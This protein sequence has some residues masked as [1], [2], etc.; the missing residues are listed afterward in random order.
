MDHTIVSLGGGSYTTGEW[1][2][3]TFFPQLVDGQQP[4]YCVLAIPRLAQPAGP[5]TPKSLVLTC[6]VLDHKKI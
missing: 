6:V 3:I 1:I 2:R 4:V 5:F